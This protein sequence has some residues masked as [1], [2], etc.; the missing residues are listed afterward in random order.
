MSEAPTDSSPLE[1]DAA[2]T[3]ADGS[4]PSGADVVSETEAG[5]SSAAAEPDA[6][7]VEASG[8]ESGQDAAPAKNMVVEGLPGEEMTPDSPGEVGEVV[9]AEG[10]EPSLP[11]AA[12]EATAA[13]PDEPSGDP[14]AEKSAKP[15]AKRSAKRPRKRK[16]KTSPPEEVSEEAARFND[17]Q[18][19]GTPVEGR[20]F[21]WNKGGFHVVVDG[22]AAFCPR[23]EMADESIPKPDAFIDQTLEFRVVRVEENGRR[24]ILSRVAVRRQTAQATLRELEVGTVVDG[25]V[26]SLTD[27]GAFVDVGGIEGLVHVS[28]ISRDRV[29]SPGDVLEVGQTVTVKV[30]RLER[31]GRRISLS[32]KALQPDPWKGVEDR[33]TAGSVVPGTVERTTQVGAFIALEP[34]LTGLMPTSEMGL[35]RD[36]LPARVYSPG[37]EVKVQIVTLDPRRKRISLAPEGAH[38]GGSR[39]DYMQYVKQHKSATA[40]G[41]N[42]LADAFGRA[43][44]TEE[45]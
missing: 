1:D 24:I 25:T 17:L 15:R 45:S 14:P 29:E 6:T 26:S 5:S 28:E 23:S 37:R 35:P 20:V 36:A 19:K 16:K 40:G 21:G 27:F 31:S 34:G 10:S 7:E 8:D 11:A 22:V 38:K 44:K 42:A 4:E 3:L 13:S 9:D 30:I 41:F 39:T 12:S 43:D 33:Y 18:D 2:S 32:M